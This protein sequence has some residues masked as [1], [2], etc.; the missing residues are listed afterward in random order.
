MKLHQS[1][2]TRHTF[3]VSLII[4]DLVKNSFL[5]IIDLA[6]IMYWLYI[7]QHKRVILVIT[8]ISQKVQD[9]AKDKY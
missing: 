7:S 8:Y 6:D 3:R 1:T 5:L 2:E 9:E 4:D